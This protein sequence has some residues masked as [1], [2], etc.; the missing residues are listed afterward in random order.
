MWCAS[1]F[2]CV[3]L[4]VCV[5]ACLTVIVWFVSSCLSSYLRI[6]LSSLRLVSCGM[7]LNRFSPSLYWLLF[8]LRTS[9]I[10]PT[11]SLV[12][13]AILWIGKIMSGLCISYAIVEWLSCFPR[14]G[15]FSS[16]FSISIRACSI[17][18]S[19][20][21]LCLYV[22]PYECTSKLRH[23]LT[24]EFATQVKSTIT[25]LNCRNLLLAC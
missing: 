9:Y 3:C 6:S 20:R 23:I 12:E 21:T 14:I 19:T 17:S 7:T 22:L 11:P 5:L 10:F 13:V 18:Q 1:S 24:F 15:L 8:R 25:L 2:V 16:F 4:L